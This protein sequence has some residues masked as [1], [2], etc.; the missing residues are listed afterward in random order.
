M[1][2]ERTK[3]VRSRA[4]T[5]VP[6]GIRKHSLRSVVFLGVGERDDVLRIRHGF[7]PNDSTPLVAWPWDRGYCHSGLSWRHGYCIHNDGGR[8]TA[9]A[10]AGGTWAAGDRDA[11]SSHG[12]GSVCV[13]GRHHRAPQLVYRWCRKA[14]AFGRAME[15]FE[16]PTKGKRY[17]VDDPARLEDAIADD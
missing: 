16:M 8:G 15:P 5:Q 3:D 1:P 12:V 10:R 13:N 17:S 11:Y 4:L 7:Q 9:A 14:K 2:L 6:R